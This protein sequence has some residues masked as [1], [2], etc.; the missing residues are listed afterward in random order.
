MGRKHKKIAVSND[1][2][3]EDALSEDHTIAESI[4]SEDWSDAVDDDDL[5]TNQF[6]DPQQKENTN[7]ARY[8]KLQDVLVGV[9]ELPTEKRTAKREA[10]LKLIFKG[11]TQYATGFAGEDLVAQESDNVRQACLY[12]LR[13]GSPSEQYAACRCLEAT[14]VIL[15]ADRNDW[16]ESID[17]YLRR[18]VINTTKAVAVRSSALRALSMAVFVCA[19]DEALNEN[20]MDLCEEIAAETYRNEKTPNSLRTTGL[21]CWGLLATTVADFYLAGKDD[22]TEGRG[23]A[24]LGLLKSCL[25]SSSLELREAA[26]ECM[27]LIHEARLSL[28]ILEEEAENVTARR[29]RSGSWDGS[30]FEILMDEVKQLIADLSV[31][32]RKYLS[33]KVKKQ[34]RATFRDFMST[35]VD[36]EPPEE[37]VAFRGGTLTLTT[38]REIIQLNFMR[39]CLQGGFQIQLMTNETLQIIFGLDGA[40]ISQS[41]GMS[42]LEKRLIMSKT[43]EAAKEK[44][45]DM[46]KK[47]DKRQNVK[48]HFLT[49]DEPF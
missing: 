36:D 49:V 16:C 4:F 35:L 38:W 43:S 21:D 29:Y 47:R 17:K 42:Q 25:E 37:I 48:N 23:L 12:S 11:L 27:S 3:G 13:V 10:S 15:G 41:E 24:I 18:A 46:T 14:S 22:V 2:L 8:L 32:S 9:E 44:D 19:S 30:E 33:K 20:L 31:E 6:E 34:Q 7:Q 26:G 5:L 1:L 28:G 40:A 45:M 39:H